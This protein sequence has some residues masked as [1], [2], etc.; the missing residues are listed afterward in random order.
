M[1]FMTAFF[2]AWS[3]IFIVPLDVR[4]NKMQRNGILLYP[5]WRLVVH[6][7]PYPPHVFR[8]PPA[9][10]A[11]TLDASTT[12]T[13]MMGRNRGKTAQELAAELVQK[14]RIPK[15]K[16]PVPHEEGE[17]LNPEMV[18]YECLPPPWGILTTPP[19]FFSSLP[20]NFSSF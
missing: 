8:V 11:V 18:P 15:S 9:L 12:T 7:L 17:A 3:A 1:M 16:N 20:L 2:F 13:G 5:L 19:P 14:K 10:P 4:C 6:T